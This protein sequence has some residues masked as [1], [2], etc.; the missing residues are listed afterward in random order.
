MITKQIAVTIY[1]NVT[2]DE[3]KFTP[4]FMSEFN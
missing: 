1:V 4:E 3:T 2:I